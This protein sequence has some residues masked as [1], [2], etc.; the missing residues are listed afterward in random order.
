MIMKYFFTKGK[1]LVK[2]VMN[3]SFVI[4]TWADY[5]K[6]FAAQRNVGKIEGRS[7]LGSWPNGLERMLGV[8]PAR[9][10]LG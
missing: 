3:T 9:Y 1:G 5:G 2:D 10:G 6:G 4:Q 8:A 7:G